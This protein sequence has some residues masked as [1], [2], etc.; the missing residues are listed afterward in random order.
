MAALLGSGRLRAD[1]SGR[2]EAVGGVTVRPVEDAVLELAGPRPRRT[3]VVLRLPAQDELRLTGVAAALVEAGLLRRNPFARLRRSA[4]GHQLTAAGRRA[5]AEWQQDPGRGALAVAL[6]GPGAMSDRVLRE[7]VF[8]PAGETVGAPRRGNR[9]AW[10]GG[11][12]A[13]TFSGGD[14]GGGA[15]GCGDGGGG[16]G[17]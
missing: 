5:L 3:V 8:F 4:A 7:R 10:A 14:G 9:T 12:S 11:S 16:G 17:C 2:L 6:D 15:G 13:W 1:S